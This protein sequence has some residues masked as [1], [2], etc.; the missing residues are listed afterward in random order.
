[1]PYLAVKLVFKYA[2]EMLDFIL[3]F[4]ALGGEIGVQICRGAAGALPQTPLGLRPNPRW[5]SA[6]DPS[7]GPLPPDPH[8]NDVAFGD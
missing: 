4:F 1:M 6:P 2:A 3:I 5:G 8:F 7:W